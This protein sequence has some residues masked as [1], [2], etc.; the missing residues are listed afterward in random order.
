MFVEKQDQDIKSESAEG[1]Q[2][3]INFQRFFQSTTTDLKKS[4]ITTLCVCNPL[5]WHPAIKKCHHP[6]IM[7]YL[8]NNKNIRYSW[9]TMLN[10]AEQWDIHH[11]EQYTD[12]R[13]NS[14]I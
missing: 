13:V 5:Q 4:D 6:V 2:I 3:A 9:V 8:V 7:N 11:S 12:L 10:Q 14:Y 1:E